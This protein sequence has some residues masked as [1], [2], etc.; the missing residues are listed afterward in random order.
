[1]MLISSISDVDRRYCKWVENRGRFRSSE[2][3]LQIR[4]WNLGWRSCQDRP[5]QKWPFLSILRRGI[6]NFSQ[7]HFSRIQISHTCND[8]HLPP[9]RP[10][11]I[12]HSSYDAIA[13]IPAIRKDIEEF[14]A[15]IK[16]KIASGQTHKEIRG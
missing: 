11:L 7:H 9:Q 5:P 4:A 1:M 15:Q 6:G 16:L 2:S 3:I 12:R 8:H 10:I 14:R 13:T